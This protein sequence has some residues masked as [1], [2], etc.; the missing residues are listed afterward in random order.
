MRSFACSRACLSSMVFSSFANASARRLSLSLSVRMGSAPGMVSSS[1]PVSRLRAPST[2]AYVVFCGSVRISMAPPQSAWRMRK[3]KMGVLWYVP[4]LRFA[5]LKRTPWPM[6]VGFAQ[7][8]HQMANGISKRT[9]C[10][11]SRAKLGGF[12]LCSL[13]P[14]V[15]P[16]TS[17]GT[18][19]PMLKPCIVTGRSRFTRDVG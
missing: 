10:V 2:T 19:R 15:V 6:R 11:P 13:L 1:E 8:P 3:A 14:V 17:G 16:S 12:F 18:Y 9:V 7:C 5:A 4:T